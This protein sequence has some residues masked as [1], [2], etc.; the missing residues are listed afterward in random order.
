M[1]I[2]LM[3]FMG[4]GKTTVGQ[5]VAEKLS[6]PFIDVDRYIEKDAGR[7]VREIFAAD[8]EA[9]FRR[10]EHEAVVELLAGPEAVIALGGGAV[11]HEG[12]RKELRNC[13]AIHLE[14]SYEEAL[15][16]IGTDDL[17]PMVA[18]SDIEDVYRRRLPD[19]RSAAR[20]SVATD[21][22]APEDVVAQILELGR[23]GGL[24]WGWP[25]K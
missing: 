16:R 25:V 23:N 20:I 5:L 10:L 8:G 1:K 24:G 4:A 19:Y 6:M 11:E 2:V 13:T 22:R 14:V 12:T 15:R 17:R 18:R 9:E 7:A 21:G 3:G